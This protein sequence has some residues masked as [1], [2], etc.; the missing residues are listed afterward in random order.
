MGGGGSDVFGPGSEVFGPGSFLC[1]QYEVQFLP[2]DF[3][4][5][6]NPFPCVYCRLAKTIILVPHKKITV[7]VTNLMQTVEKGKQGKCV[8]THTKLGPS[9]FTLEAIYILHVHSIDL[10]GISHCIFRAPF[11]F[12]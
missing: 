4:Y 1:Y 6:L 3:E 5:S 8:V 11:W 9:G 2:F 12:A 10:H 7:T